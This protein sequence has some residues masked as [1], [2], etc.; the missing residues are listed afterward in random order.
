M[1]N[2]VFVLKF[3]KKEVSS[4]KDNCFAVQPHTHTHTQRG[5]GVWGSRW[6]WS[7]TGSVKMHDDHQKVEVEGVVVFSG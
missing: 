2:W 3:D 4:W 1:L 6:D 7:R 5:R